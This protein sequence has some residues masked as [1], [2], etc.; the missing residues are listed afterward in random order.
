METASR[1]LKEQFLDKFS[2]IFVP[3]LIGIAVVLN[4]LAL[5]YAFRW[6]AQPT[7]GLFLYPRLVVSD[8]LNPDLATRFPNLQSADDILIR[9]DDQP[10]SSGQELY[11]FLVNPKIETRVNL[12]FAQAPASDNQKNAEVILTPFPLQELLT[13]FWLPFCIGLEYLAMGFL[14]YRLRQADQVSKTFMAFCAWVSLW[15]GAF[16]DQ[17]TFHLLTPVWVVALPMVGAGLLHLA[18]VFPV[19]TRLARRKPHFL[20]LPY[21]LALSLSG[22]NLYNLYF[23]SNP[24]IFLGIWFWGFNFLALSVLV[25]LTLMLNTQ[26]STFSTVVR[27]QSLIIFWGSLVSLGPVA[28]WA[29]SNAP[30]L[31]LQ[32][33]WFSLTTVLACFIIFPILVAYTALRYRLQDLDVIFSRAVVYAL[34]TLLVTVV[35]FLVVSFLAVQL[36]DSELFK[37]PIVFSIF[38]LMLFIALGPVREYLQRLVNRIFLREPTDYRHALQRYGQALVTTTLDTDHILGLL[39]NQ[40]DETLTPEK[41]LIFL[42]D[43]NVDM[44]TIRD[45]RS[46][47]SPQPVEVSFSPKD[48][49]VRWLAETKDVLQLSP[50]GVALPQIK[51]SREEL[52]RLNMLSITACVPFLGATQL[53]GW[54]ALSSRNT[55]QPYTNND[56][57]FLTTLAS[58]TTIALESALLLEQAN[59]RAAELE[60]LQKIS[61]DIQTEAEPDLLLASIVRRATHLLRAAGGLVYLMEPDSDTLKLT[62]SHNLG[63]DYS[64]HTLKKGE[65]VAGLV[66]QRREAV[67]VDH[68]QSFSGRSPIFK[69]AKLGAVL[70]VPLLWGDSVH[71][72]LVVTHRA[73][74]ARFHERD[75]WLMELFA[76][77]AAIA[78][79]KSHLLKEARHR[80]NQ[81]A[82]LSEVSVAISSTLDLDTALKRVMDCA[83]QILSAEAGSLL[84]LDRNGQDLTFEVVL[85]PTGSELKGLKTEVG[86]GIVGTV[87]LTG[88]PLII[89]EAANDPR[90]N[91]AFDEA[92]NF[93]TRDI[94]CVPMITRERVVG[95]VEVINKQDGTA[96]SQEEAALLMSFGAQAAIAIENAQIFGGVDKALA[97][98]VQELQ[99][100]QVF[101][102]EL[103]ASLELKTVLDVTLTRAMDALG[104]EMGLMGI[105][106]EQPDEE[107]GVYLLAQRGM[108]MEMSRY[109]RDPW[110]LTRGIIGRVVRTGDLAWVNDISQDR[111]Y[112]PNSFRSRSVLVVPIKREEQVIGVI[113]LESPSPDYFTSDDVNFIKLLV[114]PA[115]I[116][117]QNAQL[118]EQVKEANQAKTDFMDRVSHDLKLPMT[119]IKGYAKLLQMSAGGAW[120]DQQKE[121]LTVISNNVDRMARMVKDLLDFSRIEAGRIRLEIQDVQMGEVID[122]VIGSVKPQIQNK[123]LDLTVEVEENLPEL[124]ADYGRIVEIVTNFVSNAYK[125]TPKGGEI[126]VKA[127][128]YGY[129]GAIEGVSVTVKDT[130]YGIS[131]EDQ[132]KLF[133]EKFFRSNDPKIRDEPGT[134]LGLWITKTMIETHGG[135]LT[136]E[137]ELGHGTSFTFT[138]PLICKIPA[139]VEVVER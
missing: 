130:G 92:T 126:Y 63:A 76:A 68:Y 13:F 7:I 65:D 4:A 56:L 6:I 139:G 72:V 105:L 90:W 69:E 111:D 9:I 113:D 115:A 41:T 52:A 134:G 81:L 51:I 2:T 64:G 94:L 3:L 37:D 26:V 15:L 99:A 45:Q 49:L 136:F 66:F 58:Q 83:V 24:H 8:T 34:L 95:V 62:Y 44:Y 22:I 74:A 1:S 124:R 88:Q 27:Q 118:F 101:D 30:G 70:G 67:V 59:Q 55:G 23:S 96:F 38:I 36:Q 122:E 46:G 87:A 93:R 42:K 20:Y 135:E 80:A 18:F 77:Q 48:N 10:V 12:S 103:Q 57:D 73:R 75:I 25:F 116:A 32:S 109:K 29:L 132:A 40:I 16:F 107:P 78:L 100:L 31:K 129:N 11:A 33:S 121:F 108:P 138:L 53:L 128:S 39:L 5:I 54:L 79:E 106:R 117:I 89:N 14:V 91:V 112:V 114:S 47:N 21:V 127:K 133:N 35:Y 86:K 110:P 17:Y 71:G 43:A 120:N 84:L 19:E 61:A 104:I 102:R 131:A 137:S 123:E 28:L 85:G 98:R 82:T 125:Y 60:A 50:N 119:S 97:E